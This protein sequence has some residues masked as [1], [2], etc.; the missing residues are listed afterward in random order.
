MW[1]QTLI[2]AFVQ[3]INLTSN[4]DGDGDGDGDDNDE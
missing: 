3:E 1:Q 2:P 4:E